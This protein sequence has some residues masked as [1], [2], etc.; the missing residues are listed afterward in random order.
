M[1]RNSA[2]LSIALLVCTL[3]LPMEMAAAQQARRTGLHDDTS[4]RLTQI[5]I[6]KENLAFAN[7]SA[8]LTFNVDYIYKSSTLVGEPLLLCGAKLSNPRGTVSFTHRDTVHQ[9]AV[10][11][12]NAEKINPHHLDLL[13]QYR[14]PDSRVFYAGCDT[15]IVGTWARDAY[16]LSSSPSWGR[17]LCEVAGSIVIAN[18]VSMRPRPNRIGREWCESLQG[19]YLDAEAAKELFRGRALRASGFVVASLSLDVADLVLEQTR[20]GLA[21]RIAHRMQTQLEGALNDS[22]PGML[23]SAGER[24]TWETLNG[25]VRARLDAAAATETATERA[26]TLREAI[27]TV[28]SAEG[29]DDGSAETLRALQQALARR[30]SD[31]A[32]RE[33]AERER[34]EASRLQGERDRLAADI[35]TRL[36]EARVTA[37]IAAAAFPVA[38]QVRPDVVQRRQPQPDA[39]V[40][41]TRREPERGPETRDGQR[42]PI[43]AGI[44]K[45]WAFDGKECPSRLAAGAQMSTPISDFVDNGDGT[46]LHRKTGLI[47]YRCPVGTY[48]EPNPKDKQSYCETARFRGR[49]V[50]NP[51]T[52]HQEMLTWVAALKI[53]QRSWRL[54]THKELESIREPACRSSLQ[55]NKAVFPSY[56]GKAYWTSEPYTAH[57]SSGVRVVNLGLI[58]PNVTWSTAGQKHA[59]WA[60]AK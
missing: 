11:P 25:E 26:R 6:R 46:V 16:N 27:R 52:T 32:E 21:G 55:L 12:Q 10:T 54:P 57:S 50:D 8:D 35:E 33:F 34:E 49:G 58:V 36:Q 60:V 40:A 13:V 2:A 43:T 56:S 19:R 51:L 17:F 45:T 48:F 44:G 22:K 59:A 28:L 47:W 20:T 53:G 24:K 31:Q 41:E 9:V 23:A 30:L 1:L 3:M 37:A 39:A 15:G 4:G 38:V 29:S 42:I 5:P 7:A 14:L 18:N